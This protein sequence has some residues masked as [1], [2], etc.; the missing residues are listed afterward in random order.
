MI[1][2]PE[3]HRDHDV[4]ALLAST[5]RTALT[6]RPSRRSKGRGG[7]PAQALIVFK[8]T[9]AVRDLLA[10]AGSTRDRVR[11]TEPLSRSRTRTAQRSKGPANG[12]A[13]HRRRH[14]LHR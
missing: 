5:P 12:F 3:Q 1:I 10:I 9:A 11:R 4:K 8:Q 6:A 2:S 14:N 13:S 7:A